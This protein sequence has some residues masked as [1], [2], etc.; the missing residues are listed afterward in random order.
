MAFSTVVHQTDQDMV[1]LRV[2]RLAG[3]HGG[4]RI[5]SE[6]SPGRLE[7]RIGHRTERSRASVV[8]RVWDRDVVG[9]VEE[10]RLIDWVKAQHA[11]ESAYYGGGLN[12][13]A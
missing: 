11:A 7:Y 3:C 12:G 1:A 13:R 10:D 6:Y 9:S 5:T 2:M 8:A 4:C